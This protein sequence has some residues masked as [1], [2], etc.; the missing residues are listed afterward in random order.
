MSS[1]AP[2]GFGWRPAVPDF[3]DYTPRTPAVGDLLAQLGGGSKAG[4]SRRPAKVDL[5]EYFPA[6][7]DQQRLNCSTAHAC[8]ALISYYERRAFGRALQPSCRFLYKT[9]RKLIGAHG[10]SGADLRTAMKAMVRFGI[11]DERYCPYEIERFDDE[12][13]AFLY[14]FDREYRAACY[15]RL[16]AGE[17]TGGQTLDAVKA[18]LAAGFPVA[19]GFAVPSSISADGDVPF[20][21]RFDSVQGGQAVVAAGYDDRRLQTTRGALLIRNS[22]GRAWGEEGYGWLPYT[23]VRERLALDF[24]TVLR[25]DWLETNEFR[26]PALG[27]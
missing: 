18:F 12:P 10:D 14:S 21:P 6:A 15:F 9:T 22:W 17:T 13:E 19:F 8:G 4:R 27:D 5:R 25:A 3:R 2:R 1:F 7:G 24:W 11:P 26:R 16:D 20:R 23:Y